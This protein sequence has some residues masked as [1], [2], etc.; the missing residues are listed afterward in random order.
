MATT[1]CYNSFSLRFPKYSYF[2]LGTLGGCGVNLEVT[3]TDFHINYNSIDKETW[4]LKASSK[5]KSERKLCI[6]I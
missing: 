4:K 5:V 2:T 6:L 1:E 3:W